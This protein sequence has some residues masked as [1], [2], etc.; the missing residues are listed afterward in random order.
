MKKWK[1]RVWCSFFHVTCIISNWTAKHL[2]QAFCTKLTLWIIKTIETSII[3]LIDQMEAV[4]LVKEI[5]I[6]WFLHIWKIFINSIDLSTLLSTIWTLVQQKGRCCV[7]RD[8][9]SKQI[10]VLFYVHNLQDCT[11]FYSLAQ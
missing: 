3:L 10:K 4:M 5:N 2:A 9:F 11:C 7:I 8:L 6:L 1:L